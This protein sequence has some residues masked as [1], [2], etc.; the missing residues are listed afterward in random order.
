MGWRT[1][2][3]IFATVIVRHIPS[4]SLAKNWT[5]TFNHCEGLDMVRFVCLITHLVQNNT[6]L[7]SPS[8][9]IDEERRKEQTRTVLLVFWRDLAK[10][11]SILN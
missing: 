11:I 7:I 4:I 8:F 6:L 3:F 1:Y 9:R 10:D 5:S 2:E